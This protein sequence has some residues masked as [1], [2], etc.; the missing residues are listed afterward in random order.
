[1]HLS[2]VVLPKQETQVTWLDAWVV[3]IPCRRK[4]QPTLVFLLGKSHGQRSL[5]GCGP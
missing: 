4:W 5:V 2:Q 3:K 1:M